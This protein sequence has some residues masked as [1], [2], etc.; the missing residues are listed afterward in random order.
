VDLL[1]DVGLVSESVRYNHDERKKLLAALQYALDSIVLWPTDR[2]GRATAIPQIRFRNLLPCLAVLVANFD[3]TVPPYFLNNVRA[4]AT[5]EGI[6]LRLDPDFNIL[7]VIYPFSIN[8]LMRNPRVSRKAQDTFV[9]ICRNPQTRLVDWR[10]FRLLLNDWAIFT[11]HKKR[12]I[13]WDL[14]SSTG[15]RHVTLRIVQEWFLKRIRLL[16]R[17]LGYLASWELPRWDVFWMI[18]PSSSSY[19]KQLA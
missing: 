7:R 13:F 17:I 8:H 18:P 12:R 6:A 16:K 19:A 15:G 10:K 3:I 14:L 5:L 11:G 4:L 2:K 1:V 9:E